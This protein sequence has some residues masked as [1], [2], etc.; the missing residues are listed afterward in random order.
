MF[1]SFRKQKPEIVSIRPMVKEYGRSIGEAARQMDYLNE[2]LH[3]DPV[4]YDASRFAKLTMP[5]LRY[6]ENKSLIVL[7]SLV[8]QKPVYAYF[9][10]VEPG[11]IIPIDGPNE[12]FGT[13]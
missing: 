11:G 12:N 7:F 6:F 2:L 3:A 5:R 13:S 8:D 9:E 1:E 4:E 10:E